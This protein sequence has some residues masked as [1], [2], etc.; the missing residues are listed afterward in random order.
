MSGYEVSHFVSE[1]NRDLICS[2]CLGVYC[3]PVQED[4]CKHVFCKTCITEWIRNAP[5]CPLSK[6]NIS[7]KTLKKP[8]QSLMDQLNSL[9][10]RCEYDGCIEIIN[11]RDIGYHYSKCFYNPYYRVKCTRG[12]GYAVPKDQLAGHRCAE[13]LQVVAID[14]F[15]IFEEIKIFIE[16][17]DRKNASNILLPVLQN[18]KS[19][20]V[21]L[22]INF[23]DLKSRLKIIK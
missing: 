6:N 17:S 12:C 9:R 16:S 7:H 1:L 11:Y 14:F 20:Y 2:I 21:Q 19:S 13:D 15:Q 18:F 8:K 22:K 10:L 3:D 4:V 5:V 23:E